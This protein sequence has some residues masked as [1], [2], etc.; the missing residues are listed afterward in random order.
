[1]PYRLQLLLSVIIFMLIAPALI[2]L[3]ATSAPA[4]TDDSP[5]GVFVV[6]GFNSDSLAV[7]DAR[8]GAVRRVINDGH[9]DGPLAMALAHSRREL[10]VCSELTASVERYSTDTWEHLGA[11]VE[12]G[13]GGIAKPCGI[14]VAP[15]GKSIFVSDFKNSA[16]LRYDADTGAFL[17][18]AVMPH[19]GGLSGPDVGMAFTPEGELIVPSFWN[20]RLVE[21]DPDLFPTP[22]GDAIATADQGVNNPRTI[23]PMPDGS[24]LL[25]NEGAAT[26]LRFN[27]DQS[28]FGLLIDD[29]PDT[30]AD[31]SGGLTAPSG[32]TLGPDGN[33]YITDVKRS[34]VLRYHPGDGAY[35]DTFIQPGA[36]NLDAPTFI[37]YIPP[38]R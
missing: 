8:T 20:H 24:F 3:A 32:M 26:V 5:D 27:R 34:A 13:A 35:I 29:D 30:I 37:T 33:L 25:T 31:E 36:A 38:Q 17:G 23:L 21:F 9:L 15:D 16:V 11:F 2:L 28:L 19:A 1:M 6:S 7:F 10:L 12:P 14:A 18:V 4:T 22:E